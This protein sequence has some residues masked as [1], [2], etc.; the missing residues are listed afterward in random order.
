MTIQFRIV[1][2]FHCNEFDDGYPSRLAKFREERYQT[3]GELKR[4]LDAFAVRYR[5]KATREEL[6]QYL[7]L[8]LPKESDE[9]IADEATVSTVAR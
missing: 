7:R 4:A 3:A 8:L 9:S 5:V 6:V 1:Q 2:S